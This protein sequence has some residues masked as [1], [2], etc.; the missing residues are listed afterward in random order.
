MRE[1]YY[2][3]ADSFCKE[4]LR[5]IE[6]VNDTATIKGIRIQIFKQ[7][8]FKINIKKQQRHTIR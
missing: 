4:S 5:H 8:K 1:I 2:P 3:F 7:E 6:F